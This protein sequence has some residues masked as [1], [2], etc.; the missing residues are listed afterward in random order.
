MTCTFANPSPPLDLYVAI[1]NHVLA[2]SWDTAQ[3]P[4]KNPTTLPKRNSHT[5]LHTHT[6]T[7]KLSHLLLCSPSEVNV[8]RPAMPPSPELSRPWFLPFPIT[9]LIPESLGSSPVDSGL[10]PYFF[11]CHFCL[12]QFLKCFSVFNVSY[13]H[14]HYPHCYQ[15]YVFLKC[16]QNQMLSL[17]WVFVLKQ[18]KNI[19][20]IAKSPA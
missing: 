14:P 1:S 7:H 19:F 17:Q 11:C 4:P 5:S 10:F 18:N 8:L 3:V 6:H 16:K 2:S 13:P 9:L 12:K 15:Q 20:P